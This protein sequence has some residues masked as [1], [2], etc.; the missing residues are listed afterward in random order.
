MAKTHQSQSAQIAAVK[1]LDASTTEPVSATSSLEFEL[2]TETEARQ[3][4]E[5]IK[6][7]AVS[8]R[9]HLVE[10]EQR[11]GWEA[12]GYS[13]ITAC[14][15]AE[16]Q[17]SKPVLVRELKVGRIEKHHLQVPIGTYRESQLRPLSKLSSPQQY[18]AVM[19]RAHQ[20]ASERKLTANHVNLAVTEF[21]SK[22]ISKIKL[23]SPPSLS[24]QLGNLV[25][26]NCVRIVTEPYA[27]HN[28][29]WA[30]VKEV[31]AHGCKVLL[32]GQEWN[33]HWNDLKEIDLVDETLKQVARQV[34]QLL[35]RDDLDKMEREIL[36]RYHRQQWFTP[37]QLHLLQMI[38]D[39]RFELSQ[40][41]SP[42]P[43][44]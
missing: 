34:T 33:I 42:S 4:I 5:A 2:M 3:C 25:I 10:L 29:C 7:H 24:Y 27:K 15:V 1:V 18:Q 21:H 37:W 31:L 38:K 17:N 9:R 26:I 8:L 22:Q 30:V 16:F 19:A 32:M 13:S 11:R 12:L 14:L 6:Y 35:E 28:G 41:N 43:D 36:E 39:L 20:L 23:V 44:V 40:S